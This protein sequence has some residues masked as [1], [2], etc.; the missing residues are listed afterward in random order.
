MAFKEYSALLNWKLRG[1][2]ARWEKS[3]GLILTEL[4]TWSWPYSKAYKQRCKYTKGQDLW[5]QD[6]SV[7]F[8]QLAKEITQALKQMF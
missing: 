4:V 5:N 1:N 3:S 7:H 6:V 2:K 8:R